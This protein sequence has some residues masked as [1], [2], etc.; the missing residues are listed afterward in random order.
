MHFGWPSDVG[1]GGIASALM[2]T[3]RPAIL[4]PGYSI[5]AATFCK[6]RTCYRDIAAPDRL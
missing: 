3:A 5:S 6:A 2:E 4:A 1:G